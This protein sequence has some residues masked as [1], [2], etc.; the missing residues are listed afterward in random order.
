MSKK[1][2]HGHVIAEEQETCEHGHP[3]DTMEASAHQIDTTPLTRKL[4]RMASP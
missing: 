1:C 2:V 4:L 3:V